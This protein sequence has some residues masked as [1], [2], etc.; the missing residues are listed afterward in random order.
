MDLLR[1]ST[2]GIGVRFLLALLLPL[3]GVALNVW[4]VAQLCIYHFSLV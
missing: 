2:R 3:T 1:H 4:T